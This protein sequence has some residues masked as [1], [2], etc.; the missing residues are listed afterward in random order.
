M[1]S[2]SPIILSPGDPFP[3]ITKVC[4]DDTLALGGDLSVERLLDAYRNGIFPYYAF[5]GG[6]IRWCCP[7]DRFVIFPKEVHVS[8]SMRTLMNSGKYHVTFN[9]DFDDV[10]FHCATSDD[11]IDDTGAWLGPDMIKAYTELHRRGYAQSVE[12]R[13]KDGDIVGGL[14]GVTLDGASSGRACSRL[15]P[16]AR[17][18]RS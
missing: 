15:S 3:S 16:T 12:V 5:R 11:R 2:R 14:Y 8:H 1:K 9:E 7:M 4:W 18:W 17:S 13:D 6:M 10:I